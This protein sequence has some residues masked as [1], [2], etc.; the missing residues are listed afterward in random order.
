VFFSELY[1]GCG[2]VVET[3]KNLENK[4]FGADSLSKRLILEIFLSKLFL[5]DGKL[6]FEPSF[7]IKQAQDLDTIPIGRVKGN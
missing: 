5:K 2:D 7:L 6:L 1:L 3:F 4:Y